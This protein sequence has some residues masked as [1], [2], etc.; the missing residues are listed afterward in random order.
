[1]Y[2]KRLE[3]YGFKSFANRVSIEFDR[4]ITAIV[5]PNGSGKSNIVDAI[6]WVLGEQSPK[7]L[8]GGRMEDV[9][10]SGTQT[11]K[12]LGFAEVTLVLDNSDGVLPT[13]YSEVSVTRRVFRSGES[14]YYINRS[15]CRLKDIIEMFVDTGV[16]KD[17]YSI[18]GQGRV[19][20]ILSM[21]SESRREIFE[22]AAGIM[23]YKLRREEAQRKLQK[24]HE[25][26]VRV[27]DILA[28]L[29]Q[30]LTPLE[31][32]ARI[33]QQ[34][35]DLRERL[36]ILEINRFVAQ[37]NRYVNR[38]KGIKDQIELID[39]DIINHKEQLSND[40]QA[41]Y[42]LQDKLESL[43]KDIERYNE[44]RH[45]LIQKIESAKSEK[46]LIH[47]KINQYIRDNQRL[48]TEIREHEEYIRQ[49][50][51]R[52]DFFRQEKQ[53][54]D[55][56]LKVKKTELSELNSG[57]NRV[58]DEL[59]NR[60]QLAEN[61]RRGV[62]RI[63]NR[64]AEYR[65]NI[66]KNQTRSENI[67]ES[68][69][70]TRKLIDLRTDEKARLE[71]SE[72]QIKDRL[73]NIRAEKDSIISQCNDLKAK[74]NS[75]R[76]VVDRY[77]KAIQTGKQRLEGLR[78]RYQLLNDMSI[79]YEGFSR[80][81]Y[82]IVAES[83]RNK[84]LA[85]KICGV[86]AELIEVPREYEL[87]IEIALGNSLQHIVTESE[88]DAKYL[89]EFLRK[90]K[91][92]RATFL[93]ISSVRPRGLTRKEKEALNLP[94][95]VGIASQLIQFD[96]R[97]TDIFENLLGRVVITE[98]LDHAI[99][100]A[101]KFGY[102]FRI[103]TLQGDVLHP[104][105]SIS[106]GSSEQRNTGL[107]GRKREMSELQQAIRDEENSIARDQ[108]KLSEKE[109]E[110]EELELE[111]SRNEDRLQ[112]QELIR[113]AEEE[114]ALHIA[115]ELRKIN[116]ELAELHS[117]ANKLNDEL[118]L[119]QELIDNQLKEVNRLEEQNAGVQ[120]VLESMDIDLK[121]SIKQ[122]EKLESQIAEIRV[123]LA[124]LEQ[125]GTAVSQQILYLESDVNRNK[126]SIG[127]KLELIKINS[128]E[129]EKQKDALNLHQKDI[130]YWQN[131]IDKLCTLLRN[132]E[133]EKN[134]YNDQMK[135][136][137]QRIK[138]LTEA[139]GSITDKKHRFEVQLSRLEAELENLLNNMWDEYGITYNSAL[140]YVD[141][142]IK[143]NN[144]NV[145]IQSIKEKIAALGEVNINAIDELK[146]VRERYRFLE[147]Q[148][149][150]LIEAKEDLSRVIR[151]I[152]KQMEDKF[153]QEFE[154]I[155]RHFQEVFTKLFG[156]G[157]ARLILEDQTDILNSGIE[158]VAQPPGKK[159][160]NI[161]LLSGG[162]KALTAIAILFAILKRKP[163]AFCVLDEIETSLDEGNLDNLG[164]F[165]KEFSKDT[166]FIVV[167]HRR[168]T[169]QVS[170]VLYGI[171]MEEKGVSNLVS[172]R[173]ED[174]AS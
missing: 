171:V 14:E 166:Q 139:I 83:R 116:K 134:E 37:Y 136:L 106:G 174:R 77:R 85:N 6:R 109:K 105:G 156:G 126:E 5:G 137:D 78:S 95:C 16:G 15:P 141:D 94:G 26:L 70:N 89:I 45:S 50:E 52:I 33:A 68:Y 88:E 128:N 113:T 162:E 7:T 12:P 9:I 150:D 110:C 42:E 67:L 101:K 51:S 60:Q 90:N 84:L 172:V 79:T 155:N 71:S 93:P 31:S 107:L 145:E 62:V 157:T 27:E 104:G 123:E 20:E 44:S 64:I 53:A 148:R 21:H 3:I 154:Q 98:T 80:A 38:I 22:E 138:K 66:V 100:M 122:K 46:R 120:N 140:D 129:V 32:Q 117:K 91:Y 125:K 102:T 47:E 146:R 48:K 29:H 133:E 158:I 56:I 159:L 147:M 30:Q 35:L 40:E 108:T 57:L 76:E 28:E 39:G 161:S 24:A 160:Q 61:Q 65:N 73:N 163:T 17:G 167:T 74:I 118:K 153:A 143:M 87:A 119:V 8:R 23:K 99:A 54:N 112:Q 1:M 41:K 92:G 49:N 36:K 168:N 144:I 149:S 115:N 173:L 164:Q 11:R 63:I 121:E 34:Y 124:S 152:T 151:Q 86:V 130:E 82:R 142:S 4:G 165:I 10:F 25:N 75:N 127:R 114:K 72:K 135:A 96:P 111:L 131:E 13:D 58:Q 169:M 19:E 69:N 55:E 132:K 59:D 43:Q 2:L 18:I 97:Y 81:I 103:V 170:D